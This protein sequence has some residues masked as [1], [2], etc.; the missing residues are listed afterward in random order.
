MRNLNVLIGPNGVGK[1]NFISFF[2]LLNALVEENLQSFV[3]KSGGPDALLHFGRKQTPQIKAEVFFGN[4]AYKLSLE[5]T[6]DNKLMFADEFLWWNVYGDSQIGSGHFET[7]LYNNSQPGIAKYVIDALEG[8]RVY[9]FHDTSENSRMK[10]IGNI[11][12]NDFFQPDASNLAA[13][14][15]FIKQEDSKSYQQIVKTIQLIFPSFGDFNLRPIPG[16]KAKIQLEWKEKGSS[17]IFL[18][19]QFSD[20]TLRFIC[21][22]TLLLQPIDFIPE[23]IIIDEPE[24]GLHPYAIK[25]LS[26]M[27]KSISEYKQ[28]IIST[29]SPELIDE[30]SPNDII[31]VQRE[32]NQSTL[33]RLEAKHLSAWLEDYT[34]GQLWKKNVLGG[35]P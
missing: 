23:T 1:S 12:Q 21:L 20:G 25:I 3:T 4:N 2:K 34:L 14:L 16:N 22:A 18:G 11:H 32:E 10:Q 31:V 15:Y 27:L 8:W 26:G 19:H 6:A 33:K 28:V 13:F 5:P 30:F 9:H 17:E 7:H 24:L 35:R 29:Q